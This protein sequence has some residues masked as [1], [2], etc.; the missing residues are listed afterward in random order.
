MRPQWVITMSLERVGLAGMASLVF[1]SSIDVPFV[2][3]SQVLTSIVRYTQDCLNRHCHVGH[4]PYGKVWMISR[5]MADCILRC[6]MSI[7]W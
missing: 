4:G 2:L 3:I 5:N 1:V 7:I 6:A